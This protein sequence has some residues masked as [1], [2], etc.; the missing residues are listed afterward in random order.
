MLAKSCAFA[1]HTERAKL[2]ATTAN[3]FMEVGV[4]SL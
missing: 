4:P 2:S 3:L 1:R